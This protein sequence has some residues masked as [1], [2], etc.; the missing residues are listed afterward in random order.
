MRIKTFYIATKAVMNSFTHPI[1]GNLMFD[2]HHAIPIDDSDPEGLYLIVAYFPTESV[3]TMWVNTP[4]VQC[5]PHPMNN[6]AKIAGQHHNMLKG[7]LATT[8][9]DT[10]WDVA[11]KAGAFH[12]LFTLSA[13]F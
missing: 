4:G 6:G 3:A 7:K 9:N 13:F 2:E 10:V 11:N 1:H 8:P 12:A 5:L